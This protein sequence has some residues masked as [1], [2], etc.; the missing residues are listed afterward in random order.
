MS[1]VVKLWDSDKKGYRGSRRPSP[2]GK[3]EFPTKENWGK[4]L[5]NGN[6]KFNNHKF[7]EAYEK[8]NNEKNL[9]EV[10]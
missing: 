2:D 6:L 5:G 4:L 7:Q 10:F 1:C 9:F 3:I 8:L